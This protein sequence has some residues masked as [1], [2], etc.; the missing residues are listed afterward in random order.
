MAIACSLTKARQILQNLQN[1]HQLQAMETLEE[2]IV[3]CEACELLVTKS[4]KSM[5]HPA[6]TELLAAT[7][8]LELP[9]FAQQKIADYCVAH[10]SFRGMIGFGSKEFTPDMDVIT[11]GLMHLARSLCWPTLPVLRERKMLKFSV[12][13]PTFASIFHSLMG[14]IPKSSDSSGIVAEGAEPDVEMPDFGDLNAMSQL[15]VV[16]A[17]LLADSSKQ[18]ELTEAEE[19]ATLESVQASVSKKLKTSSLTIYRFTGYCAVV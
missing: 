16:A 12:S 15:A 2:R 1:H 9:I 8:N 18:D 10:S 19:A 7:K 5:T 17:P 3:Q 14:K 6:V 11:G 4:L 13:A